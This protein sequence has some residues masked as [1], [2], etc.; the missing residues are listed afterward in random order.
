MPQVSMTV[1]RDALLKQSFDKLCSEVGMSANTSINVF[2][3]QMVNYGGNPF[4]D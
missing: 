3:R 2:V 4:R 1:R